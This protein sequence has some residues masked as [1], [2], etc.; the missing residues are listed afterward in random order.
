MPLT[1]TYWVSTGSDSTAE[2]ECEE[3]VAV[4]EDWREGGKLKEL[5]VGDGALMYALAMRVAFDERAAK[6][7]FVREELRGVGW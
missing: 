4:Y 6:E 2:L 3:E 5:M 1:K 7:A